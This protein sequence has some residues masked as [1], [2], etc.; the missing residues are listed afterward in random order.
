MEGQVH[1]PAPPGRTRGSA[2][3]NFQEDRTI[4]SGTLF[5]FKQ[6]RIIVG[7][8]SRSKQLVVCGN[9]VSGRTSLI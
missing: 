1:M 3:M 9:P 7:G 8:E 5:D 4:F 6:H 2:P